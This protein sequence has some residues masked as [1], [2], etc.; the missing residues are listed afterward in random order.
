MAIAISRRLK[1]GRQLLPALWDVKKKGLR[2][3]GSTADLE[4]VAYQIWLVNR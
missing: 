3:Q 2:Q 1:L 4:V